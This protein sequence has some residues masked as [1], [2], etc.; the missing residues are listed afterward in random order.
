MKVVIAGGSGL[1]G[2]ALC[3]GLLA[4]GHEPVILSRG[5]SRTAAGSSDAGSSSDTPGTGAA[6]G[7]RRVSWDPSA[8]PSTPGEWVQEL[9]DSGAVI[10]LAGASIGHWPWTKGRKAEL[11]DSRVTAT[12]ALVEAIGTLP[13]VKRPKVFLSASG[14]DLYEGRDTTPADETTEPAETFLGK[15]CVAWEA[16]AL[17]ARDLGLRVVLVRTSP[18]IAPGAASLRIQALPFRLFVGGRLGSGQQ[19]SSW[20]DVADIVGIYLWA[21]ASDGVSGPLNATAPDP[22]RQVDFARALGAALHRPSW[23]PT[24][25]FMIRLVLGDQAT[26]AIGSRRVWPAAALAGGYV[27]RR[28][29]LEDSLRAALGGRSSTS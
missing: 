1:I 25:A 5:A 2:T 14:S 17:R 11:L 4:A 20:V 3:Q 23:F 29:R 24:P 19:W 8:D 18:V 15:L 28:T 21:L 7:V 16:E 26:L 12:R 9:A 6:T 27:F 13:E 22:R 10:N